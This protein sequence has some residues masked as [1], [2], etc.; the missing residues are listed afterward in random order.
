M[1][2]GALAPSKQAEHADATGLRSEI[3]HTIKNFANN[4]PR[5]LQRA[6][7]PSQVGTPCTRQL[8]YLMSDVEP[9]RDV[10]DPWPSI[11]GTATHAWLADAFM[12]ANNVA[13]QQGLPT[14]WH[15]ERRVDVGFGLR[16]SCDC[17]HEPSGTV[18]D[19][20]ILGDTQYRKYASGE[21]SE[22]YR[23]QSHLYGL[24]YVRAGYTVTTVAIGMFGR[25]KRLSDLH[26]WSEPFD[27]ELA[28][29]ALDR[30]RKVQVLLQCGVAPLRIPATP[31]SACYFCSFKGDP[32][33]GLCPGKEES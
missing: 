7:G 22:T 32:D 19:W 25:A 17:F 20:K 9:S 33:K 30:M 2:L 6:V 23:K 31:G 24:G 18:L 5:S 15:L 4:A 29:R 3:I 16:G 28:L 11:L 27:I 21:M 1:A 8:G 14:P 13:R 10:H 12:H 26:I